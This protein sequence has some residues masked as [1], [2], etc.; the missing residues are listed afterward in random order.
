MATKSAHTSSAAAWELVRQ[1]HGVVA[2]RQL[3]TLGMSSAAIR[4]RLEAGRLHRIWRGV[5]AVGRPTLTK[6]GRW[7]AAVLSGG[8]AALLSHR[9]AAALWGIAGVE[10]GEIDIVIPYGQSRRRR[11]IC[12][13]R[14]RAPRPTERRVSDD[15]PVTDPVSTIVDLAG[16]VGPDGA[17]AISLDAIE[18]AINAAD[19]LRLFSAVTLAARLDASPRRPGVG[20]L[21][22]LLGRQAFTL[23][24][25]RLER[26]FLPLAKEAGLPPPRT[27]EW[28]NGFRVDFYWPE[29]GL[30]VETDGLTYHRTPSQQAEDRRRDQ[31]HTAAGLTALRFT[32]AQVRYEPRYVLTILAPVVR[33][34]AAGRDTRRDRAL[35]KASEARPVRH[36]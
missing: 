24:D 15:I 18:A 22:A 9:S 12:V 4:H 28:L 11:G 13:H 27:Q 14:R 30:V 3:L 2:R 33:R 5:Y 31:A 26:L 16:L 23:T 1:Q 10:G 35:A 8:P 34:L 25:S 32:H 19:R 17:S 6:C 20:R 7:M 21:R 36:D 29:L